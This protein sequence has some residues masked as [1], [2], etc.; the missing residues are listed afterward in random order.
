MTRHLAIVNPAAG[1]G[2]AARTW[3][4]ASKR[5][6][7]L[8]QVDCVLTQKPGHARALAREAVACGYERV[9]A[10][11]GGQTL[12]RRALGVA[13]AI[14]PR[15]G[16]GMRIAPRAVVDDGLFDVCI[17]GDVTPVELLALLPRMYAG[18][19]AAHRAVEFFRC[20]DLAIE[21]L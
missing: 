4:R 21:P 6:S 10:V 5:V 2:R 18:T 12:E 15:Y 19:H 1:R 9:V 11:A 20:R 3:A 16:G 8:R 13:V 17:V 7:S 14:G